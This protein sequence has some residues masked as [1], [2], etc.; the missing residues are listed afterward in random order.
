MTSSLLTLSEAFTEALI[1][2]RHVILGRD[3]QPFC[4]DHV[5]IL[6]ALKSPL[7]F[8]GPI[9]I[10]D[11]QLAVQ[12]CSTDSTFEFYD[13]SLRPDDRWRLWKK[14]TRMMPIPLAEWNRYVD[15]YDPKFLFR[16]NMDE[17]QATKCPGMMVTA[18]RLVACGHDPAK[19]RRMGIGEMTAWSLAIV[20]KDGDPLK[21]VLDDQDV[22]FRRERAETE[23]Q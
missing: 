19:V 20:E 18:A 22:L 3:M 4:I 7:I 10:E 8:G 13:V 17:D 14:I 1:H 5:L 11:M 23:G 2:D 16:R 6:E 9:T 12:A 15:D 21:S